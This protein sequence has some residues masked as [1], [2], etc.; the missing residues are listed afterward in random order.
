MVYAISF[1][2]FEVSSLATRIK[3]D[4][5]VGWNTYTVE[6]VTFKY[7]VPGWVSRG[8]DR[9]QFQRQMMSRGILVGPPMSAINQKL[10]THRCPLNSKVL[11]PILSTRMHECPRVFHLFPY[12]ANTNLATAWVSTV[13][14]PFP[15]PPKVFIN[16]SIFLY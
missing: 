9:R 3:G 14:Q 4:T 12:N 1:N 15:S 8:R 10:C 6:R 5:G 2:T 16:I 11:K 13:Q 7:H